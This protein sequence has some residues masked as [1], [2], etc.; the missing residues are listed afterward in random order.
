MPAYSKRTLAFFRCAASNR[1][2]RFKA[3]PLKTVGA[4]GGGEGGDGGGGIAGGGGGLDG[5]ASGG[6]A[7]GGC[8]RSGGGDAR[9]GGEDGQ[10]DELDDGNDCQISNK[11]NA[12]NS[13][14]LAMI[15]ATKVGV[16]AHRMNLVGMTSAVPLQL[17]ICTAFSSM[18]LTLILL[19][20]SIWTALS[21]MSLTLIL[22]QLSIWTALSS[23]SLTLPYAT[24]LLRF[25]FNIFIFNIFAV[26][27]P[28]FFSGARN[29][30]FEGLTDL[31]V[32]VMV[33]KATGTG[34]CEIMRWQR[35]EKEPNYTDSLGWPSQAASRSGRPRV[36]S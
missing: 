10:E 16:Q 32:R 3:V 13:M 8:N 22:L 2:L 15:T 1:A 27:L 31:D 4:A 25:F 36:P 30:G 11:R 20:L 17:S 12:A 9:I 19:Q 26:V 28:C 35:G 33:C 23:M 29:L 34:V 18:P 21:L 5:G 14:E 7:Y 24:D 6:G